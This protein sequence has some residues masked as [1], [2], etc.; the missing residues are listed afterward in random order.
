MTAKTKL[1]TEKDLKEFFSAYKKRQ[2]KRRAAND[3]V[4]L[5]YLGTPYVWT[6]RSLLK[7]KKTGEKK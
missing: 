2:S 5:G 4:N 6:S 1:Y 3:L 7:K